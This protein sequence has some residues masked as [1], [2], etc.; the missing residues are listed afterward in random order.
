[1]AVGTPFQSDPTR[2]P[3][4][5]GSTRKPFLLSLIVILAGVGAYF[6]LFR[7]SSPQP[8]RAHLSFGSLEQA[9]APNIHL[10]NFK[11][12]EATNFLNQDVKILQGDIL[13][14]G[15]TTVLA[16]DGT[17]EYRDGL[18]QIALRET[19]PLLPPSREGLKPGQIAHFELSFDRVP[20]SWNYVMPKVQISGLKLSSNKK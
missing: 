17:I 5:A 11:M 8:Q 20:G 9:Y 13:N 14:A 3:Q 19:R 15:D 10:G 1:M 18:D 7:S 6:L 12:Q 2:T 4:S 16:I